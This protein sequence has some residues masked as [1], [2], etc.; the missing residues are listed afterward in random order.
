MPTSYV[1]AVAEEFVQNVLYIIQLEYELF[2]DQFVDLSTISS[3]KDEKEVL[4]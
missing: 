2:N 3:C 4:L 1:R